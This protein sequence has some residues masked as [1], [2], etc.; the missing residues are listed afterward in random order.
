METMLRIL[1]VLTVPIAFLCCWY[2]YRIWKLNRYK[3]MF[4]LMCAFIYATI[5]RIIILFGTH[6][7]PIA[8]MIVFWITLL[9][10]KM[11][12]YKQTKKVMG[13]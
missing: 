11:D 4:W 8:A 5:L 10:A 1:N 9:Y 13:K 3:G 2:C 6:D 7:V 12:I